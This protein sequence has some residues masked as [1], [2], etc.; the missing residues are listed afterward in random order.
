MTVH[1]VVTFEFETRSPV[2]ARGTI[3]GAK[4]STCVSRAVKDA[5]RALRPSGWTSLVCVLLD[6]LETTA[7]VTSEASA[8]PGIGG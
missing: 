2:T 6:R 5:Q 7:E 8:T 1:Y 3:A 4:A